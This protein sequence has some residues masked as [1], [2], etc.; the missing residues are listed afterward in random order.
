MDL[1]NLKMDWSRFTRRVFI[2]ASA[3]EIFK[4]W[5]TQNG[6]ESWFLRSA[7]FY[8]NNDQN[9]GDEKFVAGDGYSWEW[10]GWPHTHE[11]L[12]LEVIDEKEFTFDFGESGKVRV[13]LV[14]EDNQTQVILT[15][16]DIPTDEKS[17]RDY[18]YGCSLGWSF[19]LVNLKAFIEHDI[20]LNHPNN[21]LPE[22]LKCELVNA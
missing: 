20:V 18:F 11:G 14:K 1:N 7:K 10:H 4:L 21:P 15:Q 17:I 9:A 6:M 8:R 12:I 13:E 22:S 16:Y 5:T 2:E 3:K 19:W